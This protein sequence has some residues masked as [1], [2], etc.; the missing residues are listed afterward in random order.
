[1][2]VD[3]DDRLNFLQNMASYTAHTVLVFLLFLFS[4]LCSLSAQGCIVFKLTESV[5]ILETT[6]LFF[7][8]VCFKYHKEWH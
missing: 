5:F 2:W 1:M 3:I 7:Q 6:L 8:D 4:V